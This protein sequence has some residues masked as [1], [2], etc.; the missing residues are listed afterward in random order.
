MENKRIAVFL[1][2]VKGGGAERV[3]VILA[4]EF[5]NRGFTVDLVLAQ[6]IGEY[7]TEVSSRVRI[8]DL[9]AASVAGSLFPLVQYINKS[10][11]DVML[12]ALDYVNVIAIFAK[13]IARH[14]VRLVISERSNLSINSKF[15][16]GLRARLVFPLVKLTY[17]YA[18]AIIAVSR[19]VADDLLRHINLKNNRLFVV[20]NPV[21]TDSIFQ[22]AEA[23]V[24][25]KWLA[26][27]KNSVI[28]AAGR[29]NSAKDFL[30]L[31]KAFSYVR[32][33]RD[34]KLLILG[35]GEQR[36][37]LEKLVMDLGLEGDVDLPGFVE[38]PYSYMRKSDLFVLSSI[39][40]G[41][42]NVLIQALACG[43]PVVSTNCPS[44]P[45]EILE[46]GRW[47]RL[48]PLGSSEKLAE[49]M[50]LTLDTPSEELPKGAIRAM[51]FNYKNATDN[52]LRV[53]L[54]L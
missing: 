9:K 21:V 23:P 15:S 46:H 28:L 47:G 18:D 20:Y 14:R 19:G 7:I 30:N 27:K 37:D 38:N 16:K 22:L 11:P 39:Y 4:N 43:I 17:K 10:N 12:S 25:H 53:M 6:A 44:G 51:D 35:E 34:C 26:D 33:Q 41:L 24:A 54:D 1:P 5:A 13:L 32:S 49:A 8:I 3:M 31:I 52:Y 36:K 29:L 45:D 48:V 40:E 2:S 50:M 42:P